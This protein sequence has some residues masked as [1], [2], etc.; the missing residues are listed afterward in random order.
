MPSVICTEDTILLTSTRECMVFPLEN[1]TESVVRFQNKPLPSPSLEPE[2]KDSADKNG[3][4][5]KGGR[6]LC[7]SISPCGKYFAICDDNKELSVWIWNEW[8]TIYK[9]WSLPT[10][11]NAVCFTTDSKA[12]LVADKSGDV[13][14]FDL[15]STRDTPTCLL[16]HLS[17]LLDIIMSPCGKYVITCDRDEKIRVSRFPNA[18]NI[19]SF[20]L[21]HTDFVTSL[22]ILNH[23]GEHVLLSG[24]GDGT[25]RIWKYLEGEEVGSTTVGEDIGIKEDASQEKHVINTDCSLDDNSENFDTHDL[26]NIDEGNFECTSDIKLR[27]SAVPAVKAIRCKCASSSN[28]SIVAAIIERFDGVILYSISNDLTFNFIHKIACDSGIWDFQFSCHSL[29]IFLLQENGEHLKVYFADKSYQEYCAVRSLEC[30]R[31]FEDITKEEVVGNLDNLY[32]RWFDNV[33]QYMVTKE[34]RLQK[35]AH[36]QSKL[37][38]GVLKHNVENSDLSLKRAKMEL[39]I[40]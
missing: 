9:R 40:T 5:N 19:H 8:G 12:L 6:I 37:E 7:C 4:V 24:S 16:G 3:K 15:S 38:D 25:I 13:L 34:K 31:F 28:S 20:C 1:Q 32:K 35:A 26:A 36:S 21:G 10:R 27:R 23:T 29:D 17:M 14:M 39:K 2:N 22:A 11:A 30:Q 18:Y 33:E